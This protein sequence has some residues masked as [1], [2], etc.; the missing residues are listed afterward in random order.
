VHLSPCPYVLHA[1]PIS[2]FWIDHIYF[3]K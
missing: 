1:Q 3:R 2:F